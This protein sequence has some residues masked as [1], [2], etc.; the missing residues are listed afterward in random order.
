MQRVLRHTL[1]SLVLFGTGLTLADETGPSW[2]YK[3]ASGPGHWAALDSAYQLCKLG[4]LQSPVD[5]RSAKMAALPP[6]EF[7]YQSVPLHILNNGHTIQV[8]VPAGSAITVGGKRYELIQ[9]HFHHPSESKLR[10]HGFPLELH[11][12]HKDADG[13]LAGVGVLMADGKA[14][15]II[16]QLWMY[17]PKEKNKESSPDGVLV[18]PNGLLPTNRAYYTFAG[19]LTTPPCSEDVTWFLLRTPMTVSKKEVA[20]FATEYPLNARPVQPLNGRQ[21]LMSK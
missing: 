12:V 6:I 21:V 1:V 17:I 19:S 10:G 5:V 13:K 9:F 4:K 18:D 20:T 16:A 2:S 8:N 3:G 11:F 15:P 7:A 14:N